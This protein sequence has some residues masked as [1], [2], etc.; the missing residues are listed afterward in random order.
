ML[1]QAFKRLGCRQ[2]TCNTPS[3]AASKLVSKT[4]RPAISIG[5][6]AGV[7]SGGMTGVVKQL[8]K[9]LTTDSKRTSGSSIMIV[10]LA[11]FFDRISRD[12]IAL[13]FFTEAGATGRVSP[14]TGNHDRRVFLVP[15]STN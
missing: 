2:C 1:D 12:W 8:G 5:H 3:A 14:L 11:H 6:S 13:Q 4:P 9:H 7:E 15:A 10:L